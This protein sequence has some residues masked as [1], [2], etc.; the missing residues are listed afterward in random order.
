MN[1]GRD[2]EDN[3][4]LASDEGLAVSYKVLKMISIRF[5]E[6][7]DVFFSKAEVLRIWLLWLRIFTL[8]NPF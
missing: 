3:V 7:L 8:L 6:C 4:L 5:C 1:E 2:M